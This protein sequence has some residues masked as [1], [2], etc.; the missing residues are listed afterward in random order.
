MV[1]DD[2]ARRRP[3]V[4]CRAEALADLAREGNLEKLEHVGRDGR[5]ARADELDAPA[6]RGAH[7]AEQDLVP[8]GVREAAV[9]AQVG[10]LCRDGLAREHAFDACRVDRRGCEGLVDAVE[11]ARDRDEDGRARE[12]HVFE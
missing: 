8:D 3:G 2:A 4:L 9:L 10:E 11:D 7:L 6:E 12:L 5:R 1:A